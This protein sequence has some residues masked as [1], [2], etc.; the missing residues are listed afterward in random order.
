[1]TDI[2]VSGI[3]KAFEED[4]N[5]LDGLSFEI[6]QGEHVGLIGKNGDGKTTMFR[7]LSQELEPDEGSIVIPAGKRAVSYTHLKG[8]TAT[9]V[10][11]PAVLE[12]GAEVKVP[13]FI[14]VG[15]RIKIDTRVGEYL[16]R[17]KN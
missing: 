15:D 14:D 6:T 12:T 11:K 3:T 13:L 8:D 17:A 4:N 1:M 10:T 5:I 7:L 2:S 16:E 9:N